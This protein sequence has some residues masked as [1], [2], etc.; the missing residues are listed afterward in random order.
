[1]GSFPKKLW[2]LILEKN[3]VPAQ[4]ELLSS[5][6]KK[7]GVVVHEDWLTFDK[8]GN[9]ALGEGCLIASA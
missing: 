6:N 3:T 7:G 4:C 2:E 9:N 8:R 5:M 1:M